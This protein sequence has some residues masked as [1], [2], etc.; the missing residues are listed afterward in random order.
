MVSYGSGAGSDAFVFTVTGL[1]AEVRG[2]GPTVEEILAKPTV[3]LDYT[4]YAR[5]RSKIA[6]EED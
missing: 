3:Q 4:R 5:F 6:R 2:R 1:I